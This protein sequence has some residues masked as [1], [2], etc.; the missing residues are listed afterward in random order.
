MLPFVTWAPPPKPSLLPMS[1]LSSVSFPKT[2]LLWAP[3][4]RDGTF[5]HPVIEA[6]PQVLSL[7][8]LPFRSIAHQS[9]SPI[10]PAP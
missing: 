7:S 9:P 6:D 5:V 4:L 10:F 2:E 3:R 8:L 1:I